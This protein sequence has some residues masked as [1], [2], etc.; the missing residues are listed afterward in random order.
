MI[1]VAS[2]HGGFALKQ[3]ILDHL[4]ERGEE[5]EDIG[6]YTPDSCDYPDY[7]ERAARAVVA[8]TYEKGILL[9]G[10]GIGMS[11]AA[12]KVRGARCALCFDGLSAELCRQH[13]D[14]NLLALGGR[15]IG[16]EL[17]KRIVDRF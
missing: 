3:E 2:D 14:A 17:A 4:R 7:A 15:M 16:P 12:N 1:V 9:C 11:I 5:F 10:T 8:G 13:N 6:T